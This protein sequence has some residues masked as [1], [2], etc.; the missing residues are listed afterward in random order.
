MG[1]GTMTAN[2]WALGRQGR[3]ESS[4]RSYPRRLPMAITW[5]EGTKVRDPD[6]KVYID[7]LQAAGANILGHR[8]PV[9][10]EAITKALEGGEPILHLDFP[11]PT[12]LAFFD[13]LQACLPSGFAED[14][15]FHCASPTG[16]GGVECALRLAELNTNGY[17]HIALEGSFHGDTRGARD[18]SHRRGTAQPSAAIFVP[19]VA[20]DGHDA[21][22]VDISALER[23]LN[24]QG[25]AVA[26][27]IVEPVQGEGGSRQV[28]TP[29]LRRARARTAV[30]GR[31]MIVDEVQS[32]VARTGRFWGF[33]HAG[34]TP[35]VVVFGK[36]VGGGMPLAL[37]GYRKEFDTWGPGAFTGTNRGNT[38]AFAAGT[39]A[40]RFIRENGLAERAEGLGLRLL[41]LL[42]QVRDAAT[43]IR[44]IRGRGLMLGA[45]VV[46][47]ASPSASPALARSIQAEAFARGLIVE[48]GGS[49]GDVVRFLPPLTIAETELDT[50]ADRF[51][52]AVLA[53]E[54]L[55]VREP[56]AAATN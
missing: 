28:S 38:L 23:A 4:A 31:P 14:V 24:V 5:A 42:D 47:L 48:L 20:E 10:I 15:R 55:A 44:Q 51:G 34:I 33:E 19:F 46:S 52:S 40:L 1:E 54:R 56:P 3:I 22:D 30:A 45:E 17:R 12:K 43:C 37:I 18:V 35:D 27:L 2:D 25:S 53:A 29:W 49:N 36:G 11:T 13:E 21:D 50:I 32:G 41:G 9:V 16:A 8:H 39:A 26:S 6:D 7:C